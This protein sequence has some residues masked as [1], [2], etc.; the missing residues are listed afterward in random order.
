MSRDIASPL[1]GS[2]AAGGALS[3]PGGGAY[4]PG[5]ADRFGAAPLLP[6]DIGRATPNDG[7][8]PGAMPPIPFFRPNAFILKTF[9]VQIVSRHRAWAG[10]AIAFGAIYMVETLK[11]F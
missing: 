8:A 5:T 2:S 9:S 3:A 7:R 11:T 10:R 6:P 4:S 1:F